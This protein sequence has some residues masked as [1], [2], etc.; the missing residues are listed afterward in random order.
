MATSKPQG[1]AVQHDLARN[2]LS[3]VL[4]G[5]I[6]GVSP[7]PLSGLIDGALVIDGDGRLLAVAGRYL[8]RNLW[9]ISALSAALVG[10]GQQGRIYLQAGVISDIMVLY[11]D[12]QLYVCHVGESQRG[13]PILLATIA[14]IRTNIGFVRIRMQHAAKQLLA[15]VE[16]DAG[17]QQLLALHEED[18]ETATRTLASTFKRGL[19]Q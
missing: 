2:P 6:E 14:D 9:E 12:K 17:V 7:F 16:N 4:D 11:D 18:L 5:L 10:V 13:C 3:H 1:K 15:L 8:Q 19:T